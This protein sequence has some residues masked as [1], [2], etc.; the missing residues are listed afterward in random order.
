MIKPLEKVGFLELHTAGFII[1]VLGVIGSVFL[2]CIGAVY[3]AAE[4]GEESRSYDQFE[5]VTTITGGVFMGVSILLVVISGLLIY[6]I[7]QNRHSMLL[8]WLVIST[9][10]VV[11]S[12]FQ[13][14]ICLWDFVALSHNFLIFLLQVFFTGLNIY[15]YYVI[16]SLYTHMKMDCGNGRVLTPP[17]AAAVSLQQT[18]PPAYSPN[19]EYPT[20]AAYPTNAVYP[21]I[22]YPT[23]YPTYNKV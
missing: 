2:F 1:G 11:L 23:T 3:V 4:N 21:P 14:L 17:P 10:G 20:N 18:D 5:A 22:A 7:K 16:F 15:I 19:A 12:C 13:L 9:L 8:P 6:G